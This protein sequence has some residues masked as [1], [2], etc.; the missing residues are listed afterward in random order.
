MRNLEDHVPGK[1]VE[2]CNQL[3]ADY[4]LQY[5]VTLPIQDTSETEYEATIT[6]NQYQTF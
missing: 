3:G 2:T 1:G 4:V 5:Y 6:K